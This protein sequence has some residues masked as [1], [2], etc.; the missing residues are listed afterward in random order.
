MKQ[1]TCNT[2]VIGAGIIGIA[3]AY[4][5]KKHKPSLNVILLDS[6]QP[7]ALTSAQSGENYRNWWSHPVMTAF[8]DHDKVA[9]PRGRRSTYVQCPLFL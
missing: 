1:Q 4:Y 9:V 2:L 3:T 5:P 8:T 7:M 6:D